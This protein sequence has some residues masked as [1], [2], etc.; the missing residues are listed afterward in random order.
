MRR[1]NRRP[2]ILARSRRD[3]ITLSMT[4]N[5]AEEKQ[6]KLEEEEEKLILMLLSNLNF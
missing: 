2:Y 6:L 1:R 4:K 3:V 5:K